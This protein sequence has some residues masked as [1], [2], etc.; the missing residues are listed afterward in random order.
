[1]RLLFTSYAGSPEFT[2]PAAWLAR[3]EGYT[4]ILECLA[5]QHEVTGIERIDYE[6]EQE[7]QGVHYIFI[8]QRRHVRRFPFRLHRLIKE[9]KPDVIFINGFVFP[10]QLIQLRLQLGNG[11]RIIILHRSEKPFSGYKR[12]LQRLADRCLDAYFF[13]SAGFGDDFIEKGII[14]SRD[15]CYE[16][17]PG[18]SI[19]TPREK[20]YAKA[21]LQLGGSPL[22]LWVGRLDKNKDPVTV[23]KAFLRFSEFLPQARLYMIYQDE[24]LLGDIRGL[25]EMD[26]GNVSS[27]QL[28]G[29]M[30][31][32]A[33]E[34]WYNAAD[35]ILSGSHYEGGGMAV[36]EAMSCGCIPVVTDITAFRRVTGE[37][38][39]GLL[40]EPGNE[41]ALLDAL[42]KTTG[43]DIPAEQ[44]KVKELFR[45]E[46]SF[47][48]IARKTNDVLKGLFKIAGMLLLLFISCA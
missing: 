19:F 25:L 30:E 18:S 6:G 4:G 45:R 36:C 2:D 42:L 16:I 28:V 10:L 32:G 11:V 5:K 47:E 17:I 46:L 13:T 34:S 12:Y 15:K 24:E 31:H 48:A 9:L 33:L 35:F 26:K 43:M 14:E 39:C 27:V 20:Q 22:Y 37:G 21:S 29:Q 44:E 7:Q 40:Y 23:V 38:E 8:R 41:E 1:M 3:I